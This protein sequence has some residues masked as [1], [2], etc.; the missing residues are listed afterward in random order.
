MLGIK[1]ILDL[2][3]QILL[4]GGLLTSGRPALAPA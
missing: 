1:M 3:I 4:T 2:Y